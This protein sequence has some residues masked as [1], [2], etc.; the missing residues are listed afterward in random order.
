MNRITTHKRHG[1]IVRDLENRL[2]NSLKYDVVESHLI[3]KDGEID[4]KARKGE[5]ILLFEIKG[6]H[7]LNGYNKACCQL[8]RSHRFYRNKG[9]QDIYCFYV[10]GNRKD[11]G[12]TIRWMR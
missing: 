7:T 11:N 6:N 5:T 8:G 4:I 9:F 1:E 3:Y 12:Y 10:Y 2:F